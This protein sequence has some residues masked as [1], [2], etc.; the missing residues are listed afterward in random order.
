MAEGDAGLG[1]GCHLRVRRPLPNF[2]EPAG[3][4]LPHA[5]RLEVSW[6]QLSRSCAPGPPGEQMWS[7]GA[8]CGEAQTLE[9]G[10]LSL[11]ARARQSSASEQG[12][13]LGLL[14][15]TAEGLPL[16]IGPGDPVRPQVCC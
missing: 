11:G 5:R 3:S 10:V 2:K 1:E 6:G 4:P 15:L 14:P 7:R 13:P 8:G 12:G 9:H 16:D